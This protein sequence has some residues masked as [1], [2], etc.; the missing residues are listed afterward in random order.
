MTSAITTK[1]TGMTGTHRVLK[2]EDP[3]TPG[4]KAVIV[5]Y[6]LDA[7][8]HL[9]LELPWL[10]LTLTVT[11]ERSN[12]FMALPWKEYA[13][14]D[15]RWGRL[16]DCTTALEVPTALMWGPLALVL[17]YGTYRRRP[18]RHFWQVICA[19]GEIYGNWMT[20]GPEW[21]TGS[22]ELNPLNSWV[23]KWVY[24]FFANVLW[25][26]IPLILLIE[27]YGVLMD[28]CDRSKSHRRTDKLPGRVEMRVIWSMLA[29]FALVVVVFGFVK[30]LV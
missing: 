29:V 5:W 23:H 16:H 19:T 21:L 15:P 1:N 30:H 28:A 8:T 12:H 2:S 9:G 10:I 22:R 20:F 6:V 17:A 4:E 3:L 14:A 24:L 27:S 18:W 7:L 25:I 13:K 26:V 11:V